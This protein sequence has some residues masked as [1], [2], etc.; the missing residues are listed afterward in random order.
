MPHFFLTKI[1]R[2]YGTKCNLKIKWG[3]QNSYKIFTNFDK[4]P[5]IYEFMSKRI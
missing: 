1:Y 3:I 2:Y 4:Y 5:N